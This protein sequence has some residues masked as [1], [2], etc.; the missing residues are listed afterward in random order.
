VHLARRAARKDPDPELA[1]LGHQFANLWR[2]T[3]SA[4]HAS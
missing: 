4:L 2:R 3:R 1:R